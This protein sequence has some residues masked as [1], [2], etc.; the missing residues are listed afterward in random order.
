MKHLTW[1]LLAVLAATGCVRED[2][3]TDLRDFVQDIESQPT[4]TIPPPPEFTS[5][6]FVSYTASRERSPFEVPR[7]L[8]LEQEQAALPKSN[9]KP[10]P[11]RVQEYLET[12]R[13][14]NLSMV[15]TLTGL[16]SENLWALV[17]DG[18]GEI[19]RVQAGNYLGRNHG[20]II[21]ISD[22]QI[23]LIEIVSS[24]QDSWVER[25]RVIVLSGLDT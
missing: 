23:E 24:G 14:E 12:F 11:N 3:L 16:G 25:P 17:K 7:K 4:G 15:G 13:V 20:R 21:E 10:D 19:H 8:E 6:D 22:T 5:F 2:P 18:N 1:S 9:V